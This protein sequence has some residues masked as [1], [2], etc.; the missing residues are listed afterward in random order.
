MQQATTNPM[1]Q[2]VQEP[3]EKALAGPTPHPEP[4]DAAGTERN[5]GAAHLAGA[6]AVGAVV[7]LSLGIYGRV[8]SP[9]GLS[10]EPVDPSEVL[11]VKSTLTTVGALLALFQLLSALWLHG[12][13]PLP[14]L[15]GLGALHR[16]SGTAAFLVTLPVAYQCLW[17]LGFQTASPRVL[18]HSL[19]G[20]AFYGAFATKLLVLRSDR[21]PGWALPLVGAGLVTLLIGL[22]ATSAL[23]FLTGSL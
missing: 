20:C 17:S 2:I 4:P 3:E 21:V 12:R 16:W 18:L 10:I 7:T 1:I 23:F 14:T 6:A 9:T 22:W 13:L 11:L 5:R 8:H 15:A 19:L